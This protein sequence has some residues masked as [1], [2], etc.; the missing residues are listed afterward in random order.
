MAKLSVLRPATTPLADL[1][2]DYLNHCR[3][4]GLSPATLRGSYELALRR[5][6]LPWCRERGVERV[7][8]LDHRVFD[9]F[10]ADLLGRTTPRG[11]PITKDSVR[12]YVRP[13]RQFLTWADADGE[14]VVAKPRIPRVG[15]KRRDVL[16]RDEIAQLEA[17]CR[18]ERDK[19]IIRILGDCGL[20]LGEV[21]GLRVRDVVR[22]GHRAYLHVRGKGNRER[23]V[24]VAPKLL[25]RIVKYANSLP[26]DTATDHL[27]LA[28]RRN[29]FK[30]WYPLNKDAVANVVE[31]AAA[32]TCLPKRGL[33]PIR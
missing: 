6:L 13:V 17:S 29:V 25:T 26:P 8:E 16:T 21:A 10:S 7:D 31:L 18:R 9:A 15:R 24:P 19:L 32:R 20:R 23:R 33:P 30:E 1:V 4:A 27:F 11:T 5:I 12:A 2:D 22:S 3:A 28:V 14:H